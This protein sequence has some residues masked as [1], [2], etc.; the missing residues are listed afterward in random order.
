LS[1]AAAL[2]WPTGAALR[3][4]NRFGNIAVRVERRDKVDIRHTARGRASLPGDIQ[5]EG[6][7][8][9]VSVRA[10]PDAAAAVDIDV[11]LPYGVE[12]VAST[13][14]GSI[15]FVGVIFRARLVTEDG[16]IRVTTPWTITRLVVTSRQAPR[17]FSQPAN[18]ILRASSD[19]GGWGRMSDE[20]VLATP[21]SDRTAGHDDT[22]RLAREAVSEGEA[23]V[24]GD[25]GDRTQDHRGEA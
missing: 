24:G 18:L 23:V 6:E 22:P 16:D 9:E 19:G 1:L 15:T 17:V 25:P 7:G 12:L 8:G 2:A 10:Q 20:A 14:K 5:V 13:T 4:E 3:I 11:T 21:R